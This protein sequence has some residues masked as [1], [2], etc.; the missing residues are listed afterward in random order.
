M[1]P[2]KKALPKWVKPE[3]FDLDEFKYSQGDMKPSV[4]AGV[5]KDRDPGGTPI[6]G[7]S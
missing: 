2:N 5:E 7:P 6:S 4:E 1:E 3:I